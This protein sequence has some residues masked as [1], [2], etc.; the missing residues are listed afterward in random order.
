MDPKGKREGKGS[1]LYLE[2]E[3]TA[4]EWMGKLKGT[5]KFSKIINNY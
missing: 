3:E 5:E 4:L 2:G 1:A